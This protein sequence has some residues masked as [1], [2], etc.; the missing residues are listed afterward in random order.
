MFSTR[1]GNLSVDCG[2]AKPGESW[3]TYGKSL[4]DMTKV[5][6]S[7]LNKIIQRLLVFKNLGVISN[8]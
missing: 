1:I 4:S 2:L 6:V 7:W 5:I 8:I 3:I